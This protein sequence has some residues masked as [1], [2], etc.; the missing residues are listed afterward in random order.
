[1]LGKRGS[2]LLCLANLPEQVTRKEIRF[3]VH[4]VVDKVAGSR[5]LRAHTISQ[6]SI[7][8][9]TDIRNGRISHQGLIGIQPAK[10]A[11]E[12]IPMLEQTPFRGAQLQVRRYRHS[13]V[14]I[15]SPRSL[16][17]IFDLLSVD[18]QNTDADRYI[19]I[20][21]VT[22]TGIRAIPP[23]QTAPER[24]DAG[25]FVHGTGNA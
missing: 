11:L 14:Q 17:T 13:S 4:K 2:I 22:S 24:E 20:D 1:M 19:K 12:A 3:F 15:A 18:P 16:T 21:L 9:L 25:F 5:L 7:L 6:C 8:R 10:I 23:P